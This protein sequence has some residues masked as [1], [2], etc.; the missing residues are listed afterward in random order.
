MAFNFSP[1][2]VYN[3]KPLDF[4]A[5]ADIPEDFWKG[6]EQGR[7]AGLRD[8]LG[9]G[10]PTTPDGSIDWAKAASIVGQYDPELGMRTAAYAQKNTMNPYQ[11]GQLAVSQ[12]NAETNAARAQRP[13]GPAMTQSFKAEDD[14]DSLTATL[15]NLREAEKLLSGG[16]YEGGLA[17]VQTELG[18]QWNYGGAAEAIGIDAEKAKRSQA[19]Q[20]IMSPEAMM[21]MASQLKGSTAYQEI[22][23]FKK[24]YANPNIPKEIKEAQLARTIS[25]VERHLATKEGRIKELRGGGFNSQEEAP[26]E[27]AP[28]PYSDG[29]TATNPA[30][31]ERMLFQNGS[32]VPVE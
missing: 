15:S 20:Q 17:G 3:P 9:Q 29:Q 28:S 11:A 31:G 7:Q 8:A 1:G 12:Q 16:V 32:W 27:E 25:A 19:F 21:V 22:L 30:T 24:I 14:R 10:L 6:Q 23:E 5:L 13:S 26:A 2:G 18:S 4:S